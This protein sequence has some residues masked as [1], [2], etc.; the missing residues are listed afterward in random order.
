MVRD[1][2]CAYTLT[3]SL[4][5][6]SSSL[7]IYVCA[8]PARPQVHAKKYVFHEHPFHKDPQDF[9]VD[10]L[11]T[12]LPTDILVQ[13]A[14]AGAAPSPEVFTGTWANVGITCTF[15][16]VWLGACTDRFNRYRKV[17]AD[18]P[19]RFSM[20]TGRIR[21]LDLRLTTMISSFIS[22]RLRVSRRS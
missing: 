2:L 21:L 20:F 7:P 12:L 8:D 13:I 1:D 15:L 11:P 4:W 10:D 19:K 16:A 14:L 17:L 22:S 5:S 9:L 3:S 18:N 6:H